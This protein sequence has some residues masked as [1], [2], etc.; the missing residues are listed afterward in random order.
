MLI[1]LSVCAG[2]QVWFFVLRGLLLGVTGLLVRSRL[3]LNVSCLV[4]PGPS[5]GICGHSCVA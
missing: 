4:R 2:I 3:L 1:I 5:G